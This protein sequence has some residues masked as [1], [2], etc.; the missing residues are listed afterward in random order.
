MKKNVFSERITEALRKN[1]MNTREL[2]DKANLTEVSLW[3]II[4]GEKEPTVLAAANIA[5]ALHVSLDFLLGIE[6]E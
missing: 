3:R 5:S 1:G 2:A 4:N 6:S